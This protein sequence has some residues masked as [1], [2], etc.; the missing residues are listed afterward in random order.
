M[1]QATQLFTTITGGGRSVQP[2]LASFNAMI[3]T[4][5]RTGTAH[6]LDKLKD[7]V[8][9]V[10]GANVWID[11]PRLLAVSTLLRRCWK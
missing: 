7:T 11:A 5:A 10:C 8:A 9:K 1:S 2:N 6:A 3:A 4:F